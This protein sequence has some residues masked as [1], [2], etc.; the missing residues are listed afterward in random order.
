MC[1]E[2]GGGGGGKPARSDSLAG[3]AR[4][5]SEQ[6]G[7][8]SDGPGVSEEALHADSERGAEEE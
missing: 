7:K 1:D 8:P 3:A 2:R 4:G 6:T 5:K